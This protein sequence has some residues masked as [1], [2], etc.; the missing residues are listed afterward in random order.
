MGLLEL[1]MLGVG[2]RALIGGTLSVGGGREAT[3]IGARIAGLIL[4]APLPIAL[5][6]FLDYLQDADQG[7]VTFSYVF[8]SGFFLVES[9]LI[10]GCGFVG[11]MIGSVVASSQRGGGELYS[12]RELRES[13][14]RHGNLDLPVVDHKS[15][16]SVRKG[17]Q[18]RPS[19]LRKQEELDEPEVVEEVDE[20]AAPARRPRKRP[21]RRDDEDEEY[22][23]DDYYPR[24]GPRRVWLIVLAICVPLV[25][26]VGGLILFLVLRNISSL[27][28]YEFGDS[29]RRFRVRMPEGVTEEV[30]E[31][32]GR[33]SRTVEVKLKN[34]LHYFLK[35][36][37]VQPRPGLDAKQRWLDG[38]RSLYP[39]EGLNVTSEKPTLWDSDNPGRLLEGKVIGETKRFRARVWLVDDRF[40]FLIVRGPEGKIKSADVTRFLDSL[41]LPFHSRSR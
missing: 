7:Q 22:D 36:Q 34:G 24:R 20:E 10:L 31:V 8:E 35:E 4:A 38:L 28:E 23:E 12:T 29:G 30:K 40:Y 18:R 1:F 11:F 16:P 26:L 41:E 37:E 17:A 15:M 32:F 25:L 39:E 33:R 27:R 13:R 6:L 19:R 14:E 9:G 2:L 21:V 5:I 3:G